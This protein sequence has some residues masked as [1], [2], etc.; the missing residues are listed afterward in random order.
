MFT[1]HSYSSLIP[2]IAASKDS[3]VKADVINYQEFETKHRKSLAMNHVQ[4]DVNNYTKEIF[5]YRHWAKFVA[6]K[7]LKA[8]KGLQRIFVNL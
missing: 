7:V 4:D 6:K 1:N 5:F 8:T 3:K 2:M